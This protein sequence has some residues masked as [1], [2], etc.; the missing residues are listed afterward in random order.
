MG[1]PPTHHPL[2]HPLP[3]AAARSA[4][5]FLPL[6]WIKERLGG[7]I[8]WLGGCICIYA[9]QK[10]RRRGEERDPPRRTNHEAASYHTHNAHA[11][12]QR[13]ELGGGDR[14]HMPPRSAYT[15]THMAPPSIHNLPSSFFYIHTHTH[16]E[17]RYSPTVHTRTHV[18][19]ILVCVYLLD[20]LKTTRQRRKI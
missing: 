2:D 19:S 13:E 3:T 1:N 8:G 10:S 20:I 14:T 12:Q 5:M 11:M 18:E 6:S 16:Q 17:R 9:S 15:H 7:R 4:S